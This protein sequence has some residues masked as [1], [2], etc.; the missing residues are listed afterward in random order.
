M[1]QSVYQVHR[2]LNLALALALFAALYVA[3]STAEAPVG[4]YY[5]T[6]TNPHLDGPAFAGTGDWRPAGPG[7]TETARWGQ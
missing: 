1:R 4:G 3:A 5:G 6:V 2:A 7:E